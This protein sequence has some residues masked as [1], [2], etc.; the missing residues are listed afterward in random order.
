MSANLYP[1]SFEDWI[2]PEVLWTC[3]TGYMQ[4]LVKQKEGVILTRSCYR[5]ASTSILQSF[6]PS[7]DS[8]GYGTL[9]EI[10]LHAIDSLE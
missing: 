3:F 1:S 7:N 6:L 8:S 5:Y 2:D 4:R 9:D 10:P